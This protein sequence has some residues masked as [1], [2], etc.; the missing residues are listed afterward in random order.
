MTLPNPLAMPTMPVLI[1]LYGRLQVCMGILFIMKIFLVKKPTPI[2]LPMIDR[3]TV[4]WVVSVQICIHCISPTVASSFHLMSR[5]AFRTVYNC[6]PWTQRLIEYQRYIAATSTKSEN[7]EP[8]QLKHFCYNKK[9]IIQA[10]KRF[11]RSQDS[12]MKSRI[13]FNASLE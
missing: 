10:I 6:I 4:S 7:R 5:S 2:F 13:Q 8:L 1:L 12:L 9:H 11:H 3:L